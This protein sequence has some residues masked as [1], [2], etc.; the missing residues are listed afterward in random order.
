M[1]QL[2]VHI[3]YWATVCLK[4][5]LLNINFVLVELL[6]K[7][8]IFTLLILICALAC[9]ILLIYST[10]VNVKNT[11]LYSVIVFL[12]PSQKHA[13]AHTWLHMVHITW[14]ILQLHYMSCGWV[15]AYGFLAWIMH[16]Y[17]Y[18]RSRHVSCCYWKHFLPAALNTCTDTKS[19][20]SWHP[21]VSHK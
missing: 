16:T 8:N 19:Y 15:H 13:S 12:F 14:Q 2:T 3:S 11:I 21:T 17:V 20:H 1:K 5:K 6:C 10:R 4:S 7:Q 9:V 18:V